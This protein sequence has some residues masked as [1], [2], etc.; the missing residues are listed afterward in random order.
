MRLM[1]FDCGGLNRCGSRLGSCFIL[2]FS[3]STFLGLHAL[4]DF[5][6]VNAEVRTANDSLAK[7][8]LPDIDITPLT[9][10]IDSGKSLAS[11]NPGVVSDPDAILLRR[12][13]FVPTT[14]SKMQ[15]L[16]QGGHVIIQ[17]EEDRVDEV[18]KE[19]LRR[20]IE[21]VGTVPRHA[22]MATAP[23]ETLIDDI[24]GIHWSGTLKPSEKISDKI[25]LSLEKN[26]FLVDVHSDVSESDAEAVIQE[27][28]GKVIF[29][30]YLL[31]GTYLV[32]GNA[33]V[34]LALSE[35]D[36]VAWIW[37]ASD[38]IIEGKAVHGCPDPTGE[39]GS[40]PKYVINSDGWDG[41][42]QGTALLTYHF[43]NETTKMP[44][45]TGKAEVV[46]AM[47]EW[48]R[49]A[50]INWVETTTVGAYRSVDIGWFEGDHGDGYPFDGRPVFPYDNVLAHTF[51][52][53]PTAPEPL[54]GDIHF[55]EAEIWGAL[56]SL[57]DVALHESGHALGLGHSADPNAV[58]YAYYDSYKE[59]DLTQDDIDGI[60]SIYA[61]SADGYFVI[62]NLGTAPLEVSSVAPRYTIPWLSVDA[63]TPFTIGPGESRKVF[64]MIDWEQAPL[65][66]ADRRILVSSNDPDESPYP[67]GVYVA[68][69]NSEEFLTVPATPAR[70][71]PS[72]YPNFYIC[73]GDSWQYSTTGA[74]S[75]HG[76]PIEYSFDWG[77]GTFSEWSESKSASHT[78]TENVGSP[79]Y[80]LYN[81]YI[82]VWARCKDHPYIYRKSDSLNP[83]LNNK[84]MRV[85]W[86]N[87]GKWVLGEKRKIRWI[88]TSDSS[89]G[90]D[91]TVTIE[92]WRHGRQLATL[93]ELTPND[94]RQSFTMRSQIPVWP[95]P[96]VSTVTIPPGRGYVIK[97][98]GGACDTDLSEPFRIVN[99]N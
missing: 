73:V 69:N 57:Y 9:V 96:G 68:F 32:N 70:V 7:I 15:V 83:F 61:A 33:D 21:I 94:G 5:G 3:L 97:V 30:P 55:D 65:G 60:R 16:W 10:Q 28:G 40:L 79:T 77:D 25:R 90:G 14:E 52:L 18:V 92:L 87:G 37:P 12:N 48:T 47:N 45:G 50:S 29:N 35:S 80:P 4:A 51:N 86:P 42:G 99:Q 11:E 62:H 46:R 71:D 75:N 98:D 85:E 89:G 93:F 49:Y 34:I 31:H 64:V 24:S 84:N 82:V 27:A 72:Q 66:E 53:P 59:E 78:Y 56:R 54:A 1:G 26:Y 13:Q 67:N 19:L 39:W 58:M 36:P 20:G 74:T 2:L 76:H 81:A 88:D 43:V 91:N 95:N 41:P 8:D 23:P 17:Y 22:F 6:G 63:L 38:A 44:I